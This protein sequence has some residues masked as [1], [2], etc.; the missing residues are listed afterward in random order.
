MKEEKPKRKIGTIIKLVIAYIILF[1]FIGLFIYSAYKI[2]VWA[3][4][5]KKTAEV[6]NEIIKEADVKLSSE[7]ALVVKFEN[8]N[9][10]N[11]R[12]VG[13][14]YIQ[15]TNVNYPILQYTDNDYYLVHSFDES[16]NTAGWIFLDYRNH[17]D[18]LD[19]NTIV[20][21]HGRKDGSM[22]GSLRNIFDDNWRSNKENLK[23]HFST[24]TDSYK[25]EIFSAY[26]ISDEDDYMTTYYTQSDIDKF[27]A[28]SAYNFGVEVSE[29][30]KILTLQTCYNESKKLVIH[31]K[32]IEQTKKPA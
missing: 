16:Y 2:V 19:Q 14:I 8:I 1:L 31:A 21:G 15:N 6:T 30:D 20:F 25:F 23:V 18:E 12:T 3:I 5:N 28:R 27:K 22:F 4:E 32:L 7:D 10:K 11:D 17:Y 9:A 13:W 26:N 29:S 24:L